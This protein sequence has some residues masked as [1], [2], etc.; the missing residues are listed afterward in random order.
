MLWVTITIVTSSADL[1]DRLLDRAGSRS[2]RAP[3]T[4][5]PSAAPAGARPATGRCTAAAAGRRTAPP[6]GALRA[7]RAPR[8]TG[9]PVRGSARPAPSLSSQLDAGELEPGEHV[10]ADASSRGTGWASGTPCR[11]AAARARARVGVVDVLA[12]EQHLAGERRARDQLV[13]P[14]EDAQERRLA[15]AGRPDQRRDLPAGMSRSTRSST[16]RSPNQAL[17][18]ARLERP[19]R[20]QR[21][22]RPAHGAAGVDVRAG[23]VVDGGLS[24]GAHGGPFAVG[25]PAPVRPA[26]GDAVAA[27]RRGRARTAAGRG[28][29]A[30]ARRRSP[31]SWSVRR[32]RPRC[33][34]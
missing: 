9:R 4:A 2:G 22:A 24:L 20:R 30:P 5:R 6:P 25:G 29:P 12:V 16:L 28:P 18:P 8:S 15:A 10:V 26:A 23:A 1:G 27:E 17:H 3:S 21:C 32:L 7:G 33:R 34:R 14:V 13:H 19:R 31:R 11:P